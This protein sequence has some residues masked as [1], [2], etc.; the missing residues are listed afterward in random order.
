MKPLA[1][2]LSQLR[3]LQV[4]LWIEEGRLR[5]SAPPGT[6]TPDLLDQMRQRKTE[7][8]AFLEQVNPDTPEP[9]KLI[10]REQDLPLS[11]AQ[12]SLWFVNQLEGKNAAY[13]IAMAFSLKGNLNLAALEQA[14]TLLIERHE[15]LRT[16]IS[17]RNGFSVTIIQPKTKFILPLI[18]LNN[19][20]KSEQEAEVRQFI[21]Q[22]S[23][24]PFDLEKDSLIRASLLQLQAQEHIL[25][26]TLHHIISDG[27]STNLLHR[28]LAILYSACQQGTAS[29]LSP[30][31]I[32]Y[33][34]FAAWQRER[35]SGE[36]LQKQLSYWKQ[37]LEGIPP[38]LDLPTDYSRPKIQTY[39]GAKHSQQL[40]PTLSAA[41]KSLSQQEG[42][43]LFMTLLATFKILLSRYTGT[44]DIVVGSPVAGRTRPELEPLIGFFINTVV[45]R[46]C[47]HNNHSFRELLAKVKQV[48]L[49]AY[50]HQE[51]PFEKLVE[52]LQPERNL[53]Y[54]P[55]FQVWFNMLSLEEQ[56]LELPGLKV[57]TISSNEANAK[58]DLTLYVRNQSEGIDLE[59]VYNR[60][61]FNLETIRVMAERFQTLLENIVENPAQ[62]IGNLSVLSVQERQRLRIAK[63]SVFPHHPFV[64]FPEAAI[65]QSISARFEEQVRKYPDNVAISTKNYQWTYRELN[66]RAGAIAQTIRQLYP[67]GSQRIA[68]LFEHDAP[69]IAAILG[70][71]KAGKTYVPLD[72]TYPQLRLAYILEDSQTTALLTNHKNL[73]FAQ[74]FRSEARKIINIDQIELESLWDDF[75]LFVAPDTLAYILYTSGSTGQPKG[76]IQNHRNV[77]H[78]IRNYT[79][80]LHIAANDKL[81]LLASYSFD[82]AVM[83]IFGA[84]LNGATLYPIDIKTEGLTHLAKTLKQAEITIYHST[85]TVYRHFLDTLPQPSE[86]SE[87]PFPQ[88]RLVVMGGEE[89]VRK[90][91]EL[92]QKY[93]SQNCIF[94][95]G[96][97]PTESTVTL[98]YFIDKE[99]KQVGNLVP[100]GY[101]VEDTEVLLLNQAGIN[102]EIYG[103]IAIKSPYIAL[104]YWQKPQLT[105]AAFLPD[106]EGGNQRIYRTGDLGRLRT[107]GTIEFL[108]RKDFQVKIR[109][110][111]I[112][113]GEIEAVLNQHP[114]IKETVVV[115]P[116][117]EEG[118]KLIVAYIVP[119][120]P[121]L[122]PSLLRTFVKQH[123][124]DYMVPSEFVLLDILPLTPSGKINRLALPAPKLLNP[125]C[126]EIKTEEYPN[127]ADD[128][129]LQLVKIWENIL[130]IKPIGLSDNFFDL[131]GHSLLAVRL[132][133]KIEKVF[134]K[135][136]TLTTLFQYPTVGE[137]ANVLRQE[138]WSSPWSSL[139]PIQPHGSKPPFFYVHSLFGDV[140][141]SRNLLLKLDVDQPAYGLQ[142]KGLDG[143]ETPHTTVEEMA[144]HYIKEI[145]TIQPHGPYLL[146]GWC[147]GGV[148]AFEMAQQLHAQGELVQLLAV[149]DGYP[150][151][152]ISQS[153]GSSLD[154]FRLRI[155]EDILRLRFRIRG[156]VNQFNSLLL[157]EKFIFI[158]KQINRKIQD[159]INQFFDKFNLKKELHFSQEF[160]YLE[161]GDA[162]RNAIDK[163][164]KNYVPKVYPGKVVLFQAI[165]RPKEYAAYIKGWEELAAGGLEVNDIPADHFSIMLSELHVGLLAEKL[166][167]W[168]EKVSGS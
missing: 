123:L 113:L 3:H 12:E 77:L 118:N 129:E 159:V 32:G 139:V 119:L 101:A 54:N 114:A 40:S 67:D 56:G 105:Q 120:N 166:R 128:L 64:E 147:I 14:F 125:N 60:D 151:I 21:E 103:E 73:E 42:T 112:E 108:G 84:L 146:G 116:E 134:G 168:I 59:W 28:E 154:K 133:S 25:L 36:L 22:E 104:G 55:L 135:N 94:V 131:G 90:D 66:Q 70:V 47:W 24:Q 82:A 124:P 39:S 63:N 122:T 79:N 110:F 160:R 89:V 141:H 98:Q 85:P 61:L 13:N 88:I 152:I 148:I 75:S 149:I 1:E 33:I 137:L 132:F 20:S 15:S 91:V 96:L 57:E 150:S 65:E 158:K 163:A 93:L 29:P 50:E 78:F 140:G 126:A 143:K 17:D 11:F 27:W 72:P 99:T 31:P 45:L 9:I 53:S 162:V 95:N 165:D 52:S 164:N 136:I 102:A 109:G 81:T 86:K 145:Q 2:F 130:G 26:L 69:A 38:L 10:S 35:F 41:L 48:T 117:D 157:P 87:T 127:N 43:T 8:L 34:D 4:K 155:Y 6:I 49:G 156:S 83:D 19:L 121:T 138:G 30:L 142:A 23:L 92:Y 62:T 144:S 107:D 74:K 97:G 16:N 37:Q 80:N 100:V 106:T 18:N 167:A 5:Y 153:E 7:I 71:L 115:A 44:E 161:I 51:M 58:F 46:T 68:L 111:R 76:V